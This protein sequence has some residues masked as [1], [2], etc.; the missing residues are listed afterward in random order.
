M[1]TGFR[2]ATATPFLS[3]GVGT[4]STRTGLSDL[5]MT[6]RRSTYPCRPAPR[7]SPSRPRRS[8]PPMRAAAAPT[9]AMMSASATRRAMCT[10]TA[11][12]ARSSSPWA[13]AWPRGRSSCARVGPD[14]SFRPVP[15]APTSTSRSTLPGH[16]GSS[17]PQ[18]ALAAWAAGRQIDLQQPGGDGLRLGWPGVRGRM[19]AGLALVGLAAGVVMVAA[20]VGVMPASGQHARSHGAPGPLY[21]SDAATGRRLPNEAG[22]AALVGGRSDPRP[23]SGGGIPESGCLQRRRSGGAVIDS[24]CGGRCG[25]RGIRRGG[26]DLRRHGWAAC[27]GRSDGAVGIAPAAIVLG[28]RAG[29][30]HAARTAGDGTHP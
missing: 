1:A 16:A 13:S 2:R 10:P 24:G 29:P 5:T 21:P 6:T 17:C 20:R 3:I 8:S 11:T 28:S 19:G 9:A 26:V 7:C 18:A 12:A 30:A 4:P 25:R 22:I 14:T 15:P 23:R 27:L